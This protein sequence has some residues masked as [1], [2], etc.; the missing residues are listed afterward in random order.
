MFLNTKVEEAIK[1]TV[2]KWFILR[3]I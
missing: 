3:M 1:N 2:W